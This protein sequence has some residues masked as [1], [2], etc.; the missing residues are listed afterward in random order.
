MLPE[1]FKSN[2]TA[3]ANYDW[4]DVANGLGY[5]N[6]YITRMELSGS[7]WYHSLT[8]NTTSSAGSASDK[9]YSDSSITPKIYCSGSAF[10][11]PRVVKGKAYFS[12]QQFGSAS[13]GCKHIVSVYHI[14]GADETNATHLGFA[15]GQQTGN[16]SEEVYFPIDLIEQHFKVGDF[17]MVEV[18]Q[19]QTLGADEGLYIDPA[20]SVGKPCIIAIPFKLDIE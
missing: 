1:E 12:G 9:I 2:P 14:D 11:T 3:L 15:G 8:T 17:L 18:N 4:T 10:N 19:Q 5:V 7:G 6:F 13:Q 16:A 20:G